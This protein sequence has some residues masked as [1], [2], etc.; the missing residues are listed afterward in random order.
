MIYLII[1][2]TININ[3]FFNECFFTYNSSITFLDRWI[4]VGTIFSI[5]TFLIKMPLMCLKISLLKM[6]GKTLT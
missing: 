1:F 5:I 4:I 6:K 2:I 3:I